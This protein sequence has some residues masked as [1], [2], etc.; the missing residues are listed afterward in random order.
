M[1][2]YDDRIN[3]LHDT[4]HYYG[5]NLSR[6]AMMGGAGYSRHGV[7]QMPNGL[8]CAIGRHIPVEKRSIHLHGGIKHLY[9]YDPSTNSDTRVKIE[10]YLPEKIIRLGIEFLAAVASLHDCD[11]NWYGTVGLTPTGQ[12]E[13]GKIIRTYCTPVF[14]LNYETDYLRE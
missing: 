2:L 3:F 6:R 11:H 5:N 4:I 9:L 1:K 12:E 8:C 7:Y 10:D 14:H 13:Y